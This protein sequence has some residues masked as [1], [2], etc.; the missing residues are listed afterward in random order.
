[1]GI[2]RQTLAAIASSC[3]L[4]GFLFLYVFI[5]LSAGCEAKSE[6]KEKMAVFF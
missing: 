6:Q 2:S 3:R 1:M 4:A 5:T